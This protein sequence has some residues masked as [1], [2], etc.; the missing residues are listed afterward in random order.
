MSRPRLIN[1]CDVLD[2]AEA[3]VAR[4]GATRLTLE[5]VA[6]EAGISKARVIYDYK[7]KQALIRALI[8]RRISDEDK[9]L[10]KLLGDMAD[11]P[12]AQ[13][14]SR[15]SLTANSPRNDTQAVA[16]SLCSATTQ[17]AELMATIQQWYS[18]AVDQ[19]LESSP[20]PRTTLIA[21][22]A[23]EGIRIL[24]YLGLH[25]LPGAER[26]QTLRDIEELVTT[27]M[28]PAARPAS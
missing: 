13:I 24:E 12:N 27:R 19:V 11:A 23:V 8:Q 14:R 17:D 9:R 18:N 5:A 7:T 25:T 4:E 28:D 26:A 16:V 6:A 15:I 22:L 20:N 2:A 10:S 1:D 21:F 3:V